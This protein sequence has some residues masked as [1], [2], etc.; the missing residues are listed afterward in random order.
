M[1]LFT[2][3]EIYW[4]SVVM[5]LDCKL[6]WLRDNGF[7]PPPTQSNSVTTERISD[8]LDRED[9]WL[10]KGKASSSGGELGSIEGYL[11]TEPANSDLIRLA[12]GP[13]RHWEKQ[14]SFPAYS[15]LAKFAIEYMSAPAK[16][17]L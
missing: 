8:K 17:H 9:E 16:F 11:R 3:S 5:C 12:G 1:G 10:F 14:A 13:L 15:R 6:Q 7:N 4:I 2:E